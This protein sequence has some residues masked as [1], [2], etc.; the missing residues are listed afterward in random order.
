MTATMIT[1]VAEIF[2]RVNSLGAKLR[3]SDLPTPPTHSTDRINHSRNSPRAIRNAI[4]ETS[5]MVFFPIPRT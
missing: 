3:G 1:P 2:V 5:L 4:F